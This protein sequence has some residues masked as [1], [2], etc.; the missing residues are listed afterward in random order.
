MVSTIEKMFPLK[1]MTYTEEMASIKM[2]G[3]HL[4]Y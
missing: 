4:K 3:F 2:T 1:G